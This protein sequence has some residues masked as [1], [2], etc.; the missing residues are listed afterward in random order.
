MYERLS[1]EDIQNI[2]AIL[3]ENV[4]LIEQFGDFENH[5]KV[6]SMLIKNPRLQMMLGKVILSVL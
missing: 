3:K 2:F 4:G 5:S 6:I 1:K